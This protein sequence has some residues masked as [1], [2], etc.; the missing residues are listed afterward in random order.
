MDIYMNDLNSI[1]KS[2]VLL[3]EE[4]KLD[5]YLEQLSCA[6]KSEFF[7]SDEFS[8]RANAEYGLDI[9]EVKQKYLTKLN[10]SINECVETLNNI[11]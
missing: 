8:S 11:M 3:S 9:G 1:T 10:Q 4:K 2:L 7:N 5:N 6:L